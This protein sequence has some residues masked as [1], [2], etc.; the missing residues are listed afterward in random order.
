[1]G[2]TEKPFEKSIR[3]LKLIFLFGIPITLLFL[4][5]RFF[6]N[7]NSICLSQLIF[8]LECYACGM[9]RA[10]QHLIHFDFKI[11]Y[12]YNKLVVVI[13]PL[14]SLLWINYTLKTLKLKH[15]KWL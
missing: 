10:V 9:T 4:P 2:S 6:D 8:D 12:D 1:M 5:S 11:A 7:G 3:I 14:I 13:F 15:F